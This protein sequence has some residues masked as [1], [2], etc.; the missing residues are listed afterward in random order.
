M[1]DKAKTEVAN[2]ELFRKNL[3]QIGKYFLK[4]L[5]LYLI[6]LRDPSAAGGSRCSSPQTSDQPPPRGHSSGAA[7]S[8]DLRNR[9]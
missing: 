2:V 6:F 8:F 4:S 5:C 3:K 1:I 7:S 9:L